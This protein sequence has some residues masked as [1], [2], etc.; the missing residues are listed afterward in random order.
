MTVLTAHS[1]IE[2]GRAL[3]ANGAWRGVRHG[4]KLRMS[5]EN[6]LLGRM[7][8]CRFTIPGEKPVEITGETVFEIGNALQSKLRRVM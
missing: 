3:T 8:V 7:I 6:N 4:V 1:R 5:L 2:I